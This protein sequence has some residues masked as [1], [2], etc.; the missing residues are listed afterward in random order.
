MTKPEKLFLYRNIRDFALFMTAC[1]W[2][3]ISIFPPMHTYKEYIMFLGVEREKSYFLYDFSN[4]FIGLLLAT[5]LM[6]KNKTVWIRI[7][8]P[9]LFADCLY[10]VFDLLYTNDNGLPKGV[11]IQNLFIVLSF[12]WSLWKEYKNKTWSQI[13]L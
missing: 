5:F 2:L 8:I 12:I 7:M 11:I 10:E 1:L 13:S 4:K 6:I 3:Y 9:T